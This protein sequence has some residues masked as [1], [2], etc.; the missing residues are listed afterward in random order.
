M[1]VARSLIAIELLV[2]SASELVDLLDPLGF[3]LLADLSTVDGR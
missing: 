1:T 2:V 3:L